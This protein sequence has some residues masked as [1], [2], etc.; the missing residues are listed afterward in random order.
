MSKGEQTKTR[1]VA[2]TA[3]LIAA[4]GYHA[5]GLNQITQESGTPMGSLYYHFRGGKDELVSTAMQAG[6]DQVAQAMTAIFANTEDIP[7]AIRAVVQVLAEQLAGSA[8][9]KGCPIATVT[10]ETAATNDRIQTTAQTIYGGWQ[11]QIATFLFQHG[12]DTESAAS[13][14]RF[15]LAVIEGGLILS[16][17]ERSNAPLIQASEHL[18]AYLSSF[19]RS[20]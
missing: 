14:A 1:L 7:T 4:Q 8:Y 9:L 2:K 16:R 11:S 17:A 15:A 20:V 6:G 18:I 12:F 19:Q 3:E 5:T 10:L 13:A